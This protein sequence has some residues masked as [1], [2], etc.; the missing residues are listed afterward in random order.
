MKVIVQILQYDSSCPWKAFNVIEDIL[1]LGKWRKV[2]SLA[3]HLSRLGIF[4]K[5]TK[6]AK[7]FSPSS[8]S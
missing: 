3:D 7:G 5:S 2:D 8:R 4:V 6:I 1:R